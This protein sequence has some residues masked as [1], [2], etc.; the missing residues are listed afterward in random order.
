MTAFVDRYYPSYE[1]YMPELY[2]RS[3][4]AEDKTLRYWID[5]ARRPVPSPASSHDILA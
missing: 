5:E 2:E 3:P 4:C 1:L